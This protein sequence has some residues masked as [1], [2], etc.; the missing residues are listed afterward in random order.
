MFETTLDYY[1]IAA[2]LECTTFLPALVTS[3]VPFGTFVLGVR[4]HRQG[5]A[6]D[7]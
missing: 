3:V 6:S 2:F 1:H 5:E 4:L 7:V